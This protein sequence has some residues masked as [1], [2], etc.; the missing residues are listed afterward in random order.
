MLFE[1]LF[2]ESE[3]E[4][5]V[6]C[7]DSSKELFQPDGGEEQAELSI[8]AIKATSGFQT[9]RILGRIKNH[10]LVMLVDSGS[11]YNFINVSITKLVR[12]KGSQGYQMGVTVANRDKVKTSGKCNNCCGVMG[13]I[14]LLVIL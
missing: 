2:E 8:H 13:N 14:S 1:D 12:L 7:V 9:M 6:D 10:K 11:T 3:S 5:F 4:E